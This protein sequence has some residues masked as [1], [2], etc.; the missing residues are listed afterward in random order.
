MEDGDCIDAC[1]IDFSKAFDSVSIPK[2]LQKLAAYGISGYCFSW[3]KDFLSDRSMYVNVNNVSSDYF[4]QLSGVPQGSVLGPLCFVVFMNDLPNVVRYCNIKLYADDVKI[5]FRFP[6]DAW[7]NLLQLDLDAIAVWAKAWQLTIA[8]SKTYMLHVG[9]ENPCQPYTLNGDRIEVA[10][11]VK[12][13]GVHVSPDL[14]WSAHINEMVKKAHRVANVILHSFVCHNENVYFTAFN[15]YVKPILDYCCFV[16]SPTL[17][18]D[19]DAVENVLKC[20]SRRVFKKCGLPRLDY[21]GRLEHIG[22]KSLERCRFVSCLCMFFNIYFNFACCNALD[23]FTVNVRQSQLR[24]HNHRLF[25]PYCRS[26]VR[27]NFFVFRFLPV[28]NSLPSSVVNTNVSKAF[29]YRL[30]KLDLSVLCNFR[31]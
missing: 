30:C 4:P 23:N 2:L 24:G 14:T 8:T 11:S 1:Y 19:I 28:W 16:W 18:R 15:T 9:N 12:D 29:I 3:L 13:L 17:A 7:S 20:F 21:S 10:K 22:W 25:V 27:K 26:N 5:Y 31:F 6:R